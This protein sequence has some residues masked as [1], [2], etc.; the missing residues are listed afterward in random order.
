MAHRVLQ[1]P[2]DASVRQIKDAF[3]RLAL[4]VHPDVAGTGCAK[5]FVAIQEAHDEM[6]RDR[7]VF[8]GAPTHEAASS[9]SWAHQWQHQHDHRHRERHGRRWRQWQQ[10]QQQQETEE[11][12]AE[13]REYERLRQEWRAEHE[14]EF[15]READEATQ[16]RRQYYMRLVCAWFGAGLLLK[17]AAFRWPLLPC[18]RPS[19]GAH[20]TAR[21]GRHR[22][23]RSS[24]RGRERRTRDANS[25]GVRDMQNYIYQGCLPA[26]FNRCRYSML[27]V[28]LLALPPGPSAAATSGF[29]HR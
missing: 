10:Q 12:A 15:G 14:A 13:R 21:G 4:R 20:V 11:E 28:S 1:V 2:R 24:S 8:S 22:V 5:R 25:A 9:D 27:Y 3:K 17:L 29:E 19:A 16:Q 18:Q 26:M 6:L 7:G 23:A